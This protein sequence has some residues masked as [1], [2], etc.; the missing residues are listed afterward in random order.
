MKCSL[1]FVIKTLNYVSIEIDSKI[2][3][4]IHSNFKYMNA[5]ELTGMKQ[6]P[7]SNSRV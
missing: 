4:N 6:W 2:N 7:L 5:V 3:P 1:A